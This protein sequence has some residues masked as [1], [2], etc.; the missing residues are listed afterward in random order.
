MRV[1]GVGGAGYVG[2]HV[3]RCLKL[4]GHSAVLYDNLIRGHAE[5]ARIL[6]LP[7]VVGDIGDA[8]VL[9]SSIREHRIEAVLHFAAPAVVAGSLSDPL[10]YYRN[11]VPPTAQLLRVLEPTGVDKFVFSSTCAVYGEPTTL[12]I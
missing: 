1:L 8:K 10:E 2:S 7:L 3:A 4:A 9:D 5:V 6:E 11:N 12:P